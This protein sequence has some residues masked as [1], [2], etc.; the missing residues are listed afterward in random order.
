M[1]SVCVCVCANDKYGLKLYFLLIN[2]YVESESE[3][4]MG[5]HSYKQNSLIIF[6]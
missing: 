1:L 6:A 3:K 4:D 2:M 5:T